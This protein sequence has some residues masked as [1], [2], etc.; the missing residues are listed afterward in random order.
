M[1]PIMIFL[2]VLAV[3]PSAVEAANEKWVAVWTGSTHGPY[4]AGNAVA[5]PDLREI[6]RDNTANDQTMRM[7]V[8]PGLWTH[9]VR[10]RFS[11]AFGSTPLTI[12]GAYAGVH[13]F[14][15]AVQPGTNRPVHFGGKASVTIA[16]G[17]LLFSDPVELNYVKRAADLSDRK[18]AISFHIAGNSGPLTWHAKAMS[19]SYLSAARGGSHGAEESADAL[20][21]TTTSWFIVDAVEAFAPADTRVV[22][23][24]GDSITDGTNST[25]N[26]DDRWPDFLANRLRGFPGSPVVVVN[27]GIGGNRVI[28]PE[29][30]DKT[31]PFSGGPSA[32]DRLD[33]DV[34]SLAGINTVIWLEAINDLGG[35]KAPAAAVIEGYRKGVER[36]KKKGIR[37]IGATVTSAL[38][39]TTASGTP[40]ADARRKEINEFIRKGGLFDAVTDF[41]AATVDT[42]TGALKPEFQPNSSIGGAGD[43]LHPNRAG[44]Q[45]MANSI[46]LKLLFAR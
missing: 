10:I 24:F 38:T 33:R 16:P 37:V 35:P 1:K 45:A 18:M 32:L 31:K 30:Y 2:A 25:I 9:R 44:Y 21:F 43:K 7:V 36:M 42:Q 13:G 40:D 20:P 14:G 8:R 5:Q 41:D 6:L 22:M 12:D 3:L 39:A 29:I 11:N 26:G 27:A 34:L 4:P 19:T 28:G 17:E 15:G 23:G 46:D